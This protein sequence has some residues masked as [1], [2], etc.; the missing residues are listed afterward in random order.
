MQYT[1]GFPQV[2][3]GLSYLI[4]KNK[5]AKF[6]EIYKLNY[7]VYAVCL[8]IKDFTILAHYVKWQLS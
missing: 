8:I 3:S 2:L 4:K 6:K 7:I 1:Y 5:S